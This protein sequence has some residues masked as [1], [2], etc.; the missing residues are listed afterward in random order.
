MIR[1]LA[2]LCT[3]AAV[4][5]SPSFADHH[6]SGEGADPWLE[7]PATA[8]G[9]GSGKHVFL[10]TAEEEYRSE[11]YFPVLASVLAKHGFDCTVLFA[12][13]REDGSIDPDQIDNIPGLDR[14]VPEA[15]ILVMNVRWRH[16]P[17]DQMKAFIDYTN[18]GKPILA[19]R[20]ATHPFNYPDG[21]QSPYA[22]WDWQAG[23]TGG[24]W[25]R[26]VAGETWVTHYGG[27]KFEATRAVPAYGQGDHPLLSGVED[28]WGPSDVYGLK[29]D[30][31]TVEVVLLGL[32]LD[33][34]EKDS[35]VRADLEAVPVAWVKEY[36]G[37]TGN[38][39]RLV[40]TTMGAAQ[41]VEN[42]D[43][44]R[45]L[46]NSVLWLLDMEVPAELD[47]EPPGGF[48]ARPYGFGGHQR[49]IKPH[50]ALEK[51]TE[52]AANPRDEG[53]FYPPLDEKKISEWERKRPKSIGKAN[54]I[55]RMPKSSN[56]N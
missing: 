6:E 35:P 29:M 15:D 12:V 1:T 25:G 22:K 3:L 34:M 56:A 32:T 27:H 51:A 14:L 23:P 52:Y 48:V 4:A 45:F 16:L 38:T 54:R 49:G 30:P 2:L 37:E 43:F 40:V 50:Q 47:V 44:R 41:D 18:S 42:E 46:C 17:D 53:R 5:A 24:G 55:E 20:T 39:T 31:G 28:V 26:E 7:V 10:V 11:E 9:P 8:E 21:S 19:V 13:N 33:G 36:E